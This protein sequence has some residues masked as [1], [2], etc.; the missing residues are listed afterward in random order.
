M[1]FVDYLKGLSLK[2]KIRLA[3][4]FRIFFYFL[5]LS[6][7]VKALT[8]NSKHDIHKT[9]KTNVTFLSHHNQKAKSIIK[10]S[11]VKRTH[12]F[13]GSSI[14]LQ[15]FVWSLPEWNVFSYEEIAM[16]IILES[17]SY[18]L[19]TIKT[20]LIQAMEFKS[21]AFIPPPSSKEKGGEVGCGKKKKSRLIL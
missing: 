12:S 9:P 21:W 16:S 8:N 5:F 1:I 20:I 15:F 18:T 2:Y 17:E 13:L 7:K 6:Q 4:L 14:W 19:D 10:K 11:I 3:T